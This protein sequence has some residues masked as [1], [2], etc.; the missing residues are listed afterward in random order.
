MPAKLL[1]ETLLATHSAWLAAGR[2]SA[3]CAGELRLTVNA[4]NLR[5]KACRVR[6]L[7]PADQLPKTRAPRN[8]HGS[9]GHAKHPPFPQAPDRTISGITTAVSQPL[10]PIP[11]DELWPAYFA[12]RSISARNLIAEHYWPEV[13]RFVARFC[14]RK[15]IIDRSLLESEAAE[16]LLSMI[17]RFDTSRGFKFWTFLHPR[18]A[19]AMLDA[20]REMDFASRKSREYQRKRIAAEQKVGGDPGAVKRLLGW[21]D[22][23]YRMS[24]IP[25]LSS[26]DT[27]VAD[28]SEQHGRESHRQRNNTIEQFALAP[29]ARDD[30]T[31]DDALREML[32]GCGLAEMVICYLYHKCD[33]T[34]REIGQVMDL[35]ES[36]VSQI[37]LRAME[38]LR[39]KGWG[40]M[41]EASGAGGVGWPA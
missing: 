6:N 19:G 4:V 21:G 22:R 31:V 5:L 12:S 41:L 40:K 11:I 39:E 15:Q 24:L 20:C 36:R 27:P 34:M 13:R 35:S 30:F 23:E 25:R 26:L 14:N 8:L 10:A 3:K 17:E 7:V 9:N 18:L 32:R 16:V 1:D 2:S 29:P 38:K 33:R 37:H 28:R